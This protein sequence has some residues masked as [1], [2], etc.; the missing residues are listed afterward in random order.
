MKRKSELW[1]DVA[2]CEGWPP[3][4]VPSNH[5]WNDSYYALSLERKYNKP[6]QELVI[7]AEKEGK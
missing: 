5:A 1:N 4:N 2:V 3:H 7:E 6:Y